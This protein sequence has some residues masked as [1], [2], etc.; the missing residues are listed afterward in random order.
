MFHLAY[1]VTLS[2]LLVE[3]MFLGFRKIPFTCAHLPGKVNLTFL[4]RHVH[5]RLHDL[6]P[7]D[8]GIRGVA[9]RVPSVFGALLRDRIRRAGAARCRARP[10][11]RRRSPRWITKTRR[12]PVVRTLG[13]SPE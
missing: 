2:L 13:L 12:D 11:D 6:Q 3:L 5:L 9:E 7:H 10:A 8:G 1:G 4:A